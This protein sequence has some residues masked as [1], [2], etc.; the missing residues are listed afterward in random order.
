MVSISICIFA[1]VLPC[2]IAEIEFQT[3]RPRRITILLLRELLSPPAW[4]IASMTVSGVT[5]DRPLADILRR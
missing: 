2:D 1:G 4:T 3:L 5:R